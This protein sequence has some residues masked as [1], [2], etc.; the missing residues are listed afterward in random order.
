MLTYS[1]AH[2]C[3]DDL[4]ESDAQEMTGYSDADVNVLSFFFLK[5]VYFYSHVAQT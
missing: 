1:C 4:K 2:G 3:A 5:K